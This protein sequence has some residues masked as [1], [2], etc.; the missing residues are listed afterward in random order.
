MEDDLK[1]ATRHSNGHTN[2]ILDALLEAEQRVKQKKIDVLSALL[3][4]VQYVNFNELAGNDSDEK[5]SFKHLDVLVCEEISKLAI[6]NNWSLCKR[7][8][9]FWIFDGTH[10]YKVEDAELEAFNL[11]NY[12]DQYVY[13]TYM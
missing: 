4:Q 13:V 12:A 10:Y 1:K 3:T 8:G 11:L 7:D 5:L 6:I 9:F 2:H